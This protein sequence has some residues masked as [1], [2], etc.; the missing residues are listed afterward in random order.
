M[1]DEA[2]VPEPSEPV[3]L[4]HPF[5]LDTEMSMTFAAALAGGVALER[6]DVERADEESQAVRN[7]RGNLRVF[8]ALEA[9]GGR[10]TRESTVASSESRMVRRHTEASIFIALYDELRRTNGIAEHDDIS[11]LRPGQIVALS[12]GPA[13]APFR[14]VVDQ[15]L[16][17]LDVAVPFVGEDDVAPEGPTGANRQQRREQARQAAKQA[18]AAPSETETEGNDLSLGQIRR[19]FTALRD[20]LDR[21]GMVDV[22]IDRDDEPS[23]ILTLDKRFATDQALELLHTT[24][25]TVIG[26][27]TQVWRTDDEF[28]NLLR[29]SV[30]SLVPSLAQA[31]IWNMFAMLAGLASGVDPAEAERTARQAAGLPESDEEPTEGD[32]EIMLG[33]DV[34][35]LSPGIS[36]PAIQIL[37][38][39]I[40]A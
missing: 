14:R 22:V 2:P 34:N 29:R 39:A 25:F 36:G 7:L 5:Y 16:R 19:M 3:E 40:C 35:A 8:G 10:E 12:I 4:L 24:R 11:T 20:D 31:T 33:D 32:S 15:I 18:L 27:V 9:G 1:T 13:V 30:M 6:E 37:P 26:K 21:S 38:L 28:V 23:V 17:L